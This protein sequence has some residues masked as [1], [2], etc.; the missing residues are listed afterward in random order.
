MGD[1]ERRRTG[2]AAGPRRRAVRQLG[3]RRSTSSW[4]RAPR[5]AS[6][7]P[8][9]DGDDVYWLESRP[10]EGGRR[11]LL[12]HGLD[13]RDA[14]ADAGP[15]QGRQPRPRVRRR[16]VRRRTADGWSRRR[17]PTAACTGSTPS[18][19]AAPEAHHAG[20]PVALRG[21]VVRSRARRACTRSARRTT[22][23]GPND[24]P[25]VVN[26]LVALALDGSDGP[27]RVLVSG[28]D[29]VAG[30]APFAGRTRRSPGSS[31]TTRTCPGTRCGCGWRRSL[32]DGS[33]GGARTVAGGPG[34]SVV[35]AGVE[36]GGRP[37]RRLGRDGL[38]EP[39]RLRRPGRARRAR[40]AT[41]RPMDAELGDPAWVFGRSSYAFLPDG[42]ILAVARARRRA[43][44]SSA[45]MPTGPSR[46]SRRR[47]REFEGL[48][49]GRRQ[50]GGDR[51]R[52]ARRRRRRCAWTRRRPSRPGSSRA[53]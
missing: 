40:P 38:V 9:L 4:S 8:W 24:P 28:P 39:L 53:R 36:P 51:G 12:R 2:G 21:P 52:P 47:S 49:V 33:L 10:S 19:T 6:S 22:P 35:Q 15:V 1:G 32:D 42:A 45:S 27:G 18:G 37:A 16:L 46:R 31:G 44:G 20:G 23:T 34:V 41:S 3:T 13:G 5:S 14:R 26:E 29:F 11:T 50:G 48:R 17:R 30:A 7:E 25:L 43:T